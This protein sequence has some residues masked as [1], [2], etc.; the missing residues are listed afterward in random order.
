MRS[1]RDNEITL[2][3]SGNGLGKTHA[4]AGIAWWW[5]KSFPRSKVYTA[6]APPQSNLEKL[7]WGE[8][9]RAREMSP[10]VMHGETAKRMNIQRSEDEFMTGVLI[11]QSESDDI[12]EA[13][14]SGKHAEH[15]LWIVDEGDAVSRA[16]YNGIEGCMSGEHDRLVVFFNPRNP[17]GYIYEQILKGGG[18]VVRLSAFEHPN[19]TAGRNHIPGAVTRERTVQRINSW[20]RLAYRNEPISTKDTF[21]LPSFL[22]G[23]RAKS[24]AGVWYP[25]LRPGIYKIMDPAFYYKVLGRYPPQG[26]NRLITD[27]EIAEAR[28][29]WDT[30]VRE[31]GEVPPSSQP[32]LGIDIAERG[33]DKNVAYLRWGDFVGRCASMWVGIDAMKTADKG[34]EIYNRYSCYRADTDGTGWGSGIAPAMRRRG[35]RA[36]GVLV[37]KS[38]TRKSE[39]G[40]FTQMRDQLYWELREWIKGDTSMLPPDDLLIEELRVPTFE[41]ENGKIKIMMKDK[42]RKALR[43]SPDSMEALMMTFAPDIKKGHGRAR[44][45]QVYRGRY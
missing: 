21:E 8:I 10:H 40:I 23:C 24:R 43:R 26:D 37:A 19:V 27:D 41:I 13:R 2:V 20:C 9:G 29:R 44:S 16:F 14:S 22:V 42:M 6:A 28:A 18:N 45:Y 38:P 3:P 31:Y 35:C 32:R 25:P 1:V 7:L 11:P 17:S 4:G 34:V 36:F 15:L 39:H 33:V 12:V 5:Y 30:F